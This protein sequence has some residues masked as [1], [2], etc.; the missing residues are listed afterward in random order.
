MLLVSI[1]LI[2]NAF[3]SVAS[4]DEKA[5]AD[6]SALSNT[7][8]TGNVLAEASIAEDSSS[9]SPSQVPEPSTIGFLELGTATLVVVAIAKHRRHP[10]A[11]TL[12]D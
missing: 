9:F 5:N 8:I 10:S 4:A 6:Q 2:A 3:V 12:E 1:V 7:T 11:G